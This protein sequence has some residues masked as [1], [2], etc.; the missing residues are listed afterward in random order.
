MLVVAY[1]A[2]RQVFKSV[3]L[4]NAS[5]HVFLLDGVGAV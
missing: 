4:Q 1:K 3:F 2:V 5:D